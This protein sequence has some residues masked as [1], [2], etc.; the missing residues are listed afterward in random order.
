MEHLGLVGAVD[1]GHA[2]LFTAL[3]GV[4]VQGAQE[5][6]LGVVEM[7]DERVDRLAAM[8]E[9]K[10]VVAA[11]FQVAFLPGF[12]TEPGRSLGSRLLG[13]IRDTDALMLVIR[14]DD[15]REP[16][17]ELARLEEDLVIGD[18]ES[19]EQ[20][21]DK[22]RRAA[23][24]DKSLAP[25]IQ[26]LERAEAELGD[27]RPI[28]RSELASA[29][30]AQLGAVF[31]LTNKPPLVVVNIGVDQIDTADARAA[32]FGADA[33]AVCIELEAD[34]DVVASEGEERARLLADLGV[35]ESVVPRLTRAAL[36][37]LGRRTFLTTG[38]D[39]TRAWTFRAGST[40]PQ[41]A[42][43]I[44]SDLQRGFIRAEVIQWQELLDIGSW[45]K[46]KELGKL[47]VEGKDYAVQDGDVLEIRFNV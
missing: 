41:C 43:V 13:T 45:A 8:A 4:D 39:E 40:A 5:R 38:E 30:R 16:D 11:T 19:V 42:G 10:K 2:S 29:D 26:A 9:S 44:H 35:P 22:Q 37:L 17:R 47:R 36:H 25:E 28:Y 20:R 12:S 21:L 3:T 31:Q 33:L 27:G 1:S 23:K 7:P 46:A 32:P 15:G 14:A 18:L 24:G 34:P 6:A